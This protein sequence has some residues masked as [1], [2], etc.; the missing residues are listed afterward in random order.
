[1][2]N[3]GKLKAFVKV[4]RAMDSTG[5]GER[6][7]V[8]EVAPTLSLFDLTGDTRACVVVF[9]LNK[10]KSNRKDKRGARR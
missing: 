6:W 10:N 1:M 3:R 5:F 8:Q 9:G 2:T 7:A 4:A